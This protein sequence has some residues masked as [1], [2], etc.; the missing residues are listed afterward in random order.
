MICTCFGKTF[1]TRVV[2]D[3]ARLMLG[4]P[5]YEAYVA[6]MEVRHPDEVPMTRDA[7]FLDR[8]RARFGGGGLRCC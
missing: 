5:G 2:A 4:V 8:Q 7:F 1:D 6:H 3:A